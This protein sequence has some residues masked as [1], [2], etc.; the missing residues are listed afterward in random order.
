MHCVAKPRCF[1]DF[2]PHYSRGTTLTDL[3]VGAMKWEYDS[4]EDTELSKHFG[5][6][7]AKPK[8][9]SK[10]KEELHLRITINEENN[11]LWLC[12]LNKLSLVHAVIYLDQDVD[13]SPAEVA[14]YVPSMKRVLWDKKR[15]VGHECKEVHELPKGKHVLS[16]ANGGEKT[17]EITHVI[18]F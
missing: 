2:R 12:G 18:L 15:Y 6:L 9:R 11:F 4:A 16:I 17:L 5:Y 3:I 1:T 8:Y 10:D 14:S 13:M 7:D